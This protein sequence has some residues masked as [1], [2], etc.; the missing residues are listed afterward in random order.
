MQLSTIDTLI[1]QAR[2]SERDFAISRAEV[3]AQ[4]VR[5]GLTRVRELF[6]QYPESVDGDEKARLQAM[7]QAASVY[8]EQ[9]EAFVEQHGKALQARQQMTQTANEARRQFETIELDIYDALREKNSE[10]GQS[11]DNDP[12]DLAEKVSG[13]SKRMLDLRSNESLYIIDGS[14]EA[15]DAWLSISTE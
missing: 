6:G 14:A 8:L 4:A 5:Q 1:L 7:D 10:S 15:L 12:L 2:R 9:F 11:N 13:M 3:D